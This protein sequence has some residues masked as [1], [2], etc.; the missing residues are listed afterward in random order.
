MIYSQHL[1]FCEDIEADDEIDALFNRLQVIE[2]PTSLVDRILAS[3][4]Q[5]PAY[6]QYEAL[7]PLWE[8]FDIDG[9]LVRGDH[10][11]PS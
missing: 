10:L 6:P 11:E 1:L 7:S 2:P 9:L 3:V 5:L 4:A 8:D